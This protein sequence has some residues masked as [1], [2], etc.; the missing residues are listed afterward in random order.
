MTQT[1][2]EVAQNVA[3]SEHER[4]RLKHCESVI[5]R[6][7]QTFISV[8][9]A[10][11]EIRKGALYRA[12]HAT[13]QEYLKDRWGIT[14]QRAHQFEHATTVARILRDTPTESGKPREVLPQ[15]ERQARALRSVPEDELP[16]VWDE[17]VA[18]AGGVQ[19][20]INHLRL[21]AGAMGFDSEAEF[22]RKVAM[23]LDYLGL[24]WCHVPNGGARSK[25]TGAELKRQGV[26]RGMPDC[27]IF[28]RAPK[29]NVRGVFIELKHGKGRTSEEQEQLH[30]ELRDCGWAGFVAH[31]WAGY[32]HAMFACGYVEGV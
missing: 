31:D 2:I 27:L 5:E 6:G 10:I 8:G 12:T 26:K 15:N 4:T 32:E 16:K 13:Y 14:R 18:K 25:A 23:S 28:T 30:A 11:A 19:P 20:T 3:L 7:M 21:A 9:A 24:C 29:L 22:Q 1:D 17:A